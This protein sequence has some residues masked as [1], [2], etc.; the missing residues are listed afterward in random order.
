MSEMD[1][2]IGGI[3]YHLSLDNNLKFVD[4]N[5]TAQ[6]VNDIKRSIESIVKSA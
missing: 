6:S 3:L 1:D 4:N 2:I 5:L